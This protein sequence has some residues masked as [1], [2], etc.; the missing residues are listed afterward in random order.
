M[1]FNVECLKLIFKIQKINFSYRLN[2]L[3]MNH[4]VKYEVRP[5]DMEKMI[6]GLNTYEEC[7][8]SLDCLN[9]AVVGKTGCGK[10]AF[11]NSFR[12]LRNNEPNT[13]RECPNASATITELG[14]ARYQHKVKIDNIET[15]INFFDTMGFMDNNNTD[16]EDFLKGIMK[17]FRITEF[18]A[19][20]F[21][22]QGKLS[23]LE[24]DI[25]RF[26]EKKKVLLFFIYNQ[27][28]QFLMKQ[29][30]SIA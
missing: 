22:T 7:S 5:D 25:A 30:K 10:S 26:Y 20:I 14:Q 12:G 18:D 23:K 1:F 4:N 13:A 6:S 21:I 19:I 16:I 27:F 11:I 8:A 29:I 3:T 15:M 28:D 2:K 17:N 9:I 24:M